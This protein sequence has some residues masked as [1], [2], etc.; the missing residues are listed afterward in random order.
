MN[1]DGLS[2]LAKHVPHTAIINYLALSA[3]KIFNNV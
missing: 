3:V 2:V 1:V